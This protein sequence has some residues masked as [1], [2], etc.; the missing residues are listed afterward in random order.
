MVDSAYLSESFAHLCGNLPNENARWVGALPKHLSRL[1]AAKGSGLPREKYFGAP[2]KENYR[3]LLK[4][5]MKSQGF[6]DLLQAAA[7]GFG[8]EAQHE[9]QL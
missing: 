5:L 2:T 4:F 9:N 6:L 7:F 8:H 1:V 3:K